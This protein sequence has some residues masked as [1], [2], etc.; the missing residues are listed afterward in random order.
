VAMFLFVLSTWS[1][2]NASIGRRELF[3]LCQQKSPACARLACKQ[4]SAHVQ[5]AHCSLHVGIAGAGIGG[6]S[7]ALALLR[8]PG[9]CVGRVTIFD[10]RTDLDS[11]RGG[12]LNLNGGAAVLAKC[13]GIDIA[14]ICRP[15]KG[16]VGRVADGSV[17]GGRKLLEFDIENMVKKSAKA[18]SLLVHD[19]RVMA[20]TVM[21]DR[22]QEL[23]CNEVMKENTSLKRGYRVSSVKDDASSGKLRFIFADGRI[24]E[25]AFDL[26]IGADGLRSSMRQYVTGKEMLPRYSGIRVQFAISEPRLLEGVSDGLARTWFGDGV[27]CLQYA[28][29]AP[30]GAEQELLAICFRGDSPTDENPG[31]DE[32]DIRSDAK[33]RLERAGMPAKV[34]HVFDRCTR[35]VDVGVFYHE[36]LLS[37]RDSTGRCTLVGD[38]GSSNM[39]LEEVSFQI[40]RTAQRC[41]RLLTNPCLSL[42]MGPSF[43]GYSTCNA[44]VFGARSQ[45]GDPG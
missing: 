24:S 30:N 7:T 35:F 19:G 34:M 44:S 14:Q 12:A 10:P 39:C 6:L 29:G 9:T 15:M 42:S 3:Q 1:C 22:L 8:V 4:S 38:A 31:Y 23:L 13:Y 20:M 5:E 41:D 11:G 32:A 21:R 18:S 2:D 40:M 27:Y 26:C 45:P 36:P 43:V 33:V 28:A 16:V 37:W 25:D 17:E